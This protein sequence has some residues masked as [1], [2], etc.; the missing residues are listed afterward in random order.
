MPVLIDVEDFASK[1]RRTVKRGEMIRLGIFVALA[2][3]LEFLKRFVTLTSQY[4]TNIWRGRVG[5]VDIFAYCPNEMGRVAAALSTA[6]FLQEYSVDLVLAVGIAGGIEKEGV[7]R[8]D[9][10]MVSSVMDMAFRKISE[11]TQ[12]RTEQY[13]CIQEFSKFVRTDDFSIEE[14]ES[15]VVR[16]VRWPA[17]LR[18]RLHHGIVASA[19]E[20]IASAE[21][22]E[23]LLSAHPKILAVEMESA[24]V[25]AACEKHRRGTNPVPVS[26]IRGISDMADPSK[27]DDEWRRI[28]METVG[29]LLA[30]I[31]VRWSAGTDTT[32]SQ[33]L[34]TRLEVIDV[35]SDGSNSSK[36]V[37][38]HKLRVVLISRSYCDIRITGIEWTSPQIPFQSSDKGTVAFGAQVEAAGGWM[39]ESWG[40]E[41]AD[42]TI[43]SGRA[44]RIWLALDPTKSTFLVRTL[45][46]KRRLGTL[47]LFFMTADGPSFSL[48]DL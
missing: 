41:A 17:G 15:R 48:Q 46:E 36:I 42:L 31:F 4:G 10:A 29:H 14:W 22:V 26:I 33:P 3:E 34:P 38:K 13:R 30:T 23:R 47:T 9:V 24:G 18:P 1:P 12:F 21:W 44:F 8:G 43:Q 39:N 20:V 2:E 25:C 7:R 11:T 40:Q 28:A 6:H 5:A 19:D 37:Y 35:C 16:E 32:S 45:H 27:G